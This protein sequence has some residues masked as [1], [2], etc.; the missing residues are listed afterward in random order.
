[1]KIRQQECRQQLIARRGNWSS[2]DRSLPKYMTKTWKV[3]RILN[4]FV[5]G[6][7][8]NTESSND[9]GS[10]AQDMESQDEEDLGHV[11]PG[12]GFTSAVSIRPILILN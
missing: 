5:T 12:G 6:N 3:S 8:H 2:N 11:R 10:D 9:D 4:F 7:D 1:M